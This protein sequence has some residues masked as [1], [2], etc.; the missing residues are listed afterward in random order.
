V[1]IT[2]Y[3]ASLVDGTP[4]T[5]KRNGSDY[6]GSI[7][8]ALMRA[9]AITIWT[10]VDGVYSADPR[11]VPGALLLDEMSYTEALEFSFYG[12][13]II[14]PKTMIPAVRSKIPVWIRNTFNHTCP[15][16]KITSSI[17]DDKK[18]SR[19]NLSAT[20]NA[21]EAKAFG[22]IMGFCTIDNLSVVAVKAA[23]IGS[24]EYAP[25]VVREK[26]VNSLHDLNVPL[27]LAAQA[28]PEHSIYYCV[29]SEFGDLALSKIKEEFAEE[30][31][32]HYI[33]SVKLLQ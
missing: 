18:K 30:I 31:E 32:K 8:G 33:H 22:V 5:L 16:T 2:G 19:G 9:F 11:K 6:S 27:V 24:K 21:E 14:H 20:L 10:D 4:T 28:A 15:G 17:S 13:K 1:V 7:F 29:N 23:A 3:V 12:A 26:L 25:L